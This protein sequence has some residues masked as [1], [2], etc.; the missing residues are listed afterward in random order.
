MSKK[1]AVFIVFLNK[2]NKIYDENNDDN[3]LT[4]RN[5]FLSNLFITSP[6]LVL[7]FFVQVLCNILFHKFIIN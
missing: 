2:R 7:Y 1:S 6:D 3:K 5:V 4:I